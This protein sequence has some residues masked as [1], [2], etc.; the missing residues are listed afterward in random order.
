MEKVPGSTVKQIQ[1]ELKTGSDRIATICHQLFPR[2]GWKRIP[3]WE[4]RESSNRAQIH[5]TSL[6][7]YGKSRPSSTCS[8]D[9]N[10]KLNEAF[11]E[12]LH[13]P[14]VRQ[15]GKVAMLFGALTMC[16]Q[17][18]EIRHF[19]AQ[20]WTLCQKGKSL[21]KLKITVE[22]H[23]SSKQTSGEAL[24]N[25]SKPKRC[26]DMCR[27]GQIWLQKMTGK[28]EVVCRRPCQTRMVVNSS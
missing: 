2:V 24:R 5:L 20:C 3:W 17:H 21:L 4:M 9:L 10:R 14:T 27:T 18:H 6:N 8:L 16:T 1:S 7:R 22:Y 25:G 15:G 13:F 12:S 23:R 26:A 19:G 28:Q 11:K